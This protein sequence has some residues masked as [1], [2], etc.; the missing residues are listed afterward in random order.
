[1]D[2]FGLHGWTKTVL[3]D[4]QNERILL[5]FLMFLLGAFYYTHKIFES[6]W[7]NKKL[8]ILLHSTGWIPIN[9]YLFLL[10]Y[11]FVK[12]GNYL[13]SEIVDT[14]LLRFNFVL[15]GAYLLY[16]MIT[17]FRTYLNT[18]G[19]LWNA[20]NRNSYGVYIIHTIVM[21]GLAV[22][23]LNTAIPSLVKYLIAIVSTFVVSN[24]IVSLY[25]KLIKSPCSAIRKRNQEPMP[26]THTG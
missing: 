12:P 26:L 25:R 22:L 2:V 15:S 8:N 19:T 3:I 4:F 17:T 18:Q 21:G 1:M 13:I 9:L 14:F 6:E 16:T 7:N 11:S 10:I 5:Y 23:L 20:L 24:L